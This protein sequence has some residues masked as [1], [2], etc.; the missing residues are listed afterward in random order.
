MNIT[1]PGIYR[2]FDTE[3]YFADPCPAPALSQSLAKILIEQSPLHARQAHPRLAVPLGADE[4]EP[5]EKYVV[6]RAIGNAAHAL[7]LGR[8][9]KMAVADLP[10]WRGKKGEEFKADALA[11]GREVI[12][13]KHMLMAER[14]V[15]AGREQLVR[16][17]G[18]ERAFVVGDAEVVIAN[19]E[20]GLWLKSMIDW[21][22]PDLR[23]VWDYKTTGASASPYAMGAKMAND[24]WPVQAATIERILDVLDPA[25]AGRRTF[26]FVCQEQDEPF[27]LTVNE[28]GEGALTMGRK[29]IDYAARAWR[30]A[31]EQDCWP[32]YPL[33]II[34]PEYPGYKE[35]AWLN[36][37][38]AE[39][40]AIEPA[41]KRTVLKSLAGG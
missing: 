7:M 20:D 25:G 29:M 26:R 14:M 40:D 31:L 12:L 37:E 41:F 35:S 3:S 30:T 39:D 8:G 27:A 22:T 19:S 36:R 16:I 2:G 6:E 24:G 38:I 17:A 5:A 18:C 11:A 13:K 9:K 28:I 21:I 34:R 15:V 4:D 32:A 10:N 23:E 33:R 1:R